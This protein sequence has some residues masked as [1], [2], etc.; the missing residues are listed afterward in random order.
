LQKLLAIHKNCPILFSRTVKSELGRVILNSLDITFRQAA[1]KAEN[2]AHGVDLEEEEEEK[3][4][5]IA[6]I[7]AKLNVN[8]LKKYC[9]RKFKS[10]KETAAIKI[11]SLVIRAA[12][13]VIF[14][15]TVTYVLPL[16][17]YICVFI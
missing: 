12:Y 10:I 13:H 14:L 1:A 4:Y 15:C 9:D 6:I 7:A 8:K 17:A 5:S 3:S 16:S 11:Q 2:D